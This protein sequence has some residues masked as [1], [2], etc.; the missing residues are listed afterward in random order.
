VKAVTDRLGLLQSAPHEYRERTRRNRADR[1]CL[2]IEAIS[3]KVAA[4]DNARKSRDFAQ[5]DAL[6][7][8]LVALGVIVKDTPEGSE[9]KLE[10]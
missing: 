3:E 4:R 10:V 1:R 2:T 8:E 6:R 7:A 9:W 5:A